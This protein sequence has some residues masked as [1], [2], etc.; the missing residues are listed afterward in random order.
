MQLEVDI[1]RKAFTNAAGER[2]TAMVTGHLYW[3]PRAA[4]PWTWSAE[5]ELRFVVS[6]D[7]S[8]GISGRKLPDGA[9]AALGLYFF[10]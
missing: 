5:S 7:V 10:H 6:R 9:E 3:L 8:L 1:A 2:F 4:G